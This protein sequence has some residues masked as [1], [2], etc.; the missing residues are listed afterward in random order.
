MSLYLDNVN[1]I[2]SMLESGQIVLCPTDTIWGISCDATNKTSVDKIYQIKKRDRDKPLILLVDSLELLRRYATNIHP[3]VEDLLVHYTKPLTVIHKASSHVP[4]FLINKDK[5]IAIR[6]TQ[7][8]LLKEIISSLKRPIISTSANV[9]GEKS[10][11][12]YHDISPDIVGQVDYVFQSNRDKSSEA[13][14]SQIIKYTP[15]GELIFIR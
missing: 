4:E 7:N 5:T 9:Q 3:R 6:L 11:V 8:P 13:S 10:P 2:C 15:E 14:A 12:G 1:A